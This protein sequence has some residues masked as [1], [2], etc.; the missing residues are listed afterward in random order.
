MAPENTMAAFIKA[1]EVGADGIELDVHRTADQVL[2][3]IH[4]DKVSRTTNGDGIVE[5]LRYEDLA[6]LDAGGHFSDEFIGEKIPTLREVLSFVQSTNMSVNIEIKTGQAPYQGIEQQVVQAIT[7]SGVRD[8]VIVSS[9]YQPALRTI[10]AIDPGLPIGI[11]CTDFRPV[12]PQ[13]ARQF[14][15]V[16]VHPR[17]NVLNPAYMGSAKQLGILVHPY[18]VDHPQTLRVLQT[19][20]VDAVICNDPEHARRVLAHV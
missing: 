7:D 17:F 4:D 15:A 10:Q 12:T 6:R 9:F 8:R 14:G 3:V 2:V 16:A 13:Y 11:L 19:W 1:Y 18:T 20:G 5:Q